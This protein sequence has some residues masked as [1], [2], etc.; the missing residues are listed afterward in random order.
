MRQRWGGIAQGRPPHQTAPSSHRRQASMTKQKMIYAIGNGFMNLM[1]AGGVGVITLIGLHG[2]R[3]IYAEVKA[4]S[5]SANWSKDAR[6]KAYEPCYGGCTDC[7]DEEYAFHACKQTAEVDVPG[8]ICDGNRIWNWQNRYPDA[9]LEALGQTYKV[10]FQEALFQSFEW[11]ALSIA[12]P[13]IVGLITFVI[14]GW[15]C[16]RGYRRRFA[17]VASAIAPALAP[18]PTIVSP[19]ARKSIGTIPSGSSPAPPSGPLSSTHRQS[20]L[21]GTRGAGASVGSQLEILWEELNSPQEQSIQEDAKV[22]SERRNSTSKFRPIPAVLGIA[23][24]FGRSN[25]TGAPICKDNLTIRHFTNADHTIFGDVLGWLASE[26]S[27][28]PCHCRD[29]KC[30]PNQDRII[31][32]SKCPPKCDTCTRYTTGSLEYVDRI[33]PKVGYCGFEFVH[34]AVGEAPW[35][36]ANA[37][38]E[39]NWLVTIVV[40]TFNVS[41]ETAQQVNCLHDI[42]HQFP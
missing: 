26:C 35:R 18:P 34:V 22:T 39:K 37:M 27:E 19:P 29:V 24:L 8:I 32:S 40:N 20:D 36:V 41:G 3:Q 7:V 6:E 21:R 42:G 31:K 2:C 9:C 12:L 16:L 5:H 11:R 33:K 14:G 25:A 30:P 28:H 4:Q 23:A 10:E 38:I 17:T 13:I 1:I 15:V